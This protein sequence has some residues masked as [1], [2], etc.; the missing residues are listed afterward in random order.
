MSKEQARE[1]IHNERAI[2]FAF[3]DQYFYD[4]LR[5]KEGDKHIGTTLY[6][7]DIVKSGDTYTYNRVAIEDRPFDPNRM[8]L[9]PI[10]QDEVYN[11]HVEQNPGW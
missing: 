7:N 6:G 9:Y 1:K 8:Y 4:V 11:L 3:E 2:E 10:P 5:W